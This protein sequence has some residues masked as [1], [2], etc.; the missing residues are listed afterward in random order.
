MG[1]VK[2]LFRR[3]PDDFTMSTG[4]PRGSAE[5]VRF[6]IRIHDALRRKTCENIFRDDV[7]RWKWGWAPATVAVVTSKE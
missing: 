4:A 2:R 7:H 3:L 1:E 6:E 5:F